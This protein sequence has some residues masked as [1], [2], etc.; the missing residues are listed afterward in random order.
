[1]PDSDYCGYELALQMVE[2]SRRPGKH[3]KDY[4]QYEKSGSIDHR[5]LHSVVPHLKQTSE[6]LR[7]LAIRET[8]KGSCKM[9]LLHYG[10]SGLLKD[11]KEEWEMCGN[12]MRRSV[13]N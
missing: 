8:S 4:T 6:L 1:M 9:Q 13:Q 12:L 2:A 7:L 5:F 10:S 3:S 11:V